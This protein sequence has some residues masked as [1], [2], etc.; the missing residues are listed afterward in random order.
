MLSYHSSRL[1]PNLIHQEPGVE[2]VRNIQIF[3]INKLFCTIEPKMPH[4][5]HIV[6][7]MGS[8]EVLYEIIYRNFFQVA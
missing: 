3:F 4:L 1:K 7:L 6:H 8:A 5:I 2:K